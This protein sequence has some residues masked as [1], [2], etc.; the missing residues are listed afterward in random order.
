MNSE[1]YACLSSEFQLFKK[2]F[3]KNFLEHVLKA[4]RG[5]HCE[6][7]LRLRSGRVE[8][9]NPKAQRPYGSHGEG[10]KI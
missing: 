1:L 9:R 4:D 8:K 5:W 2:N 3:M 6:E 7:P 10:Q